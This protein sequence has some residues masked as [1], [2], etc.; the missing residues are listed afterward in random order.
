MVKP[1]IL[2]VEDE[3]DVAGLLRFL[4]VRAG[5]IVRTVGS[6]RE[7]LAEV[8]Y[9]PPD[10]I[11][12]DLMLPDL[13]GISVCEILRREP[14]TAGIPII[15]LTAWATSDAREMALALGVRDYVTKPFRPKELAHRVNRWITKT[16]VAA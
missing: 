12:L 5:F 3:R 14:Q 10:L 2:C 11:I 4:L 1:N 15:V 9:C 13:D 8:Q 6:A 16:T 7:A